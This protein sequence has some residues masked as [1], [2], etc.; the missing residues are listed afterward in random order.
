MKTEIIDSDYGL[1]ISLT[2]E[3]MEEVSKLARYALNA[4]SDKPYV[5]MYFDGDPRLSI[6]LYKRR[7]YP[8]KRTSITPKL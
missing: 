4:N 7:K 5:S 6:A 1:F 3:T 2:P 8:Q